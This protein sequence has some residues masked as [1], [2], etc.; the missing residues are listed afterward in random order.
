MPNGLHLHTIST[1]YKA[2]IEVFMKA[3]RLDYAEFVCSLPQIIIIV[4]T[5]RTTWNACAEVWWG[6][7]IQYRSLMHTHTQV[8]T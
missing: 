7:H 8:V 2:L 4:I 6:A 5:E 1:T 3:G